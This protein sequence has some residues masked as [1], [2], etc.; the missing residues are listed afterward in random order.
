MSG[1]FMNEIDDWEAEQIKYLQSRMRQPM[2][3]PWC[4]PSLTEKEKQERDDYIKLH[5]CPF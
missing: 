5:N 2:G 4:P 1:F 3:E